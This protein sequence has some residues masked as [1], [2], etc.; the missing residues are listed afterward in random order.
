LE[1]ESDIEDILSPTL[2]KIQ[3]EA[4]KKLGHEEISLHINRS[5]LQYIYE[6]YLCVETGLPDKPAE[7]ALLHGSGLTGKIARLGARLYQDGHVRKLAVLG[8][9]NR[10]GFTEEAIAITTALTNQKVERDDI[11][12]DAESRNTRENAIAA[13]HLIEMRNIGDIH[14]I[15][16]VAAKYHARRAIMTD[17]CWIANRS[18]RFKYYLQTYE[19]EGM[20]D[21]NRNLTNS[22][23]NDVLWEYWSILT[24]L[25]WGHIVEVYRE[26][27]FY[28]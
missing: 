8:G 2:K 17:K 13:R 25:G 9:L 12:V 6:E 10:S 7:V 18:E 26:K 3:L 14:S 19:R 24:Y 11:W 27:N 15:I 20:V 23:L 16:V 22:G 5:Q 4:I 1:I 21:D 28:R